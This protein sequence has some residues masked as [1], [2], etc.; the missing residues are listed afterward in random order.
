MTNARTEFGPSKPG[1]PGAEASGRPVVGQIPVED[2]GEGLKVTLVRVAAL[3]VVLYAFLYSIDLL[4]GTF[5]LLGKDFAVGLIKTTS[6]PY[7]GL[8]IGIVAT[9]LVQSSSTVTSIIVGL[10]AGGGLTV[11]GAIPIIMGANIGTSVTNTIVALGHMTRPQE[12][13]RAFAGATVH[14]FF[15]ICCVTVFLPLENATH[16]IQ[17]SAR[18]AEELLVGQGGVT[19]QSPLKAIVRPT[20]KAT[21]K[22]TLELTGS[23]VVA[24]VILITLSVVLLFLSLHFL[25][26]LMRKLILGR[27]E[28]LMHRYVFRNAF[29]GVVAGA[30]V[31]V[32]VQSSSVTTSLAVPLL[33]AGFV[34]VEQM[35]PVILGANVGT[36]ITALLASMVTGSAAALIVA[37]SHLFFNIYGIAVFYPLRR[38]PIAGAKWLGRMTLRSRGF[39][40][41]YILV[42]FFLIPLALIFVTR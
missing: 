31:T 37:L 41:G 1:S 11:T 40:V 16:F 29:A 22:F 18:W 19:F 15:N 42:V 38:I 27:V 6:N 34:T 3:I 36:T 17:K 33:A 28:V 13:Q 23:E 20:V 30:L 26:K 12:F 8:L 39:A 21:E 24:A 4:G 14:D 32:L 5:K 9:S 35:F 2:P 7:T 10:V 25:V